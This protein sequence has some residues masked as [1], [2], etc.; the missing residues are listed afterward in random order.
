MRALEEE[1]L[2]DEA[3]AL[4]DHARARLE[5]ALAN[6]DAV[7][8]VR[9]LGLMI[10]VECDTPER[11]ASATAEALRRGLI[12]LPSGSEGQVLSL[13]PPLCIGREALDAALDVLLDCIP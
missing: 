11:A 13:T 4:G 1:K 10:G 5:Q 7:R 8:E 12:L 2:V 9:G 3:L 6:R